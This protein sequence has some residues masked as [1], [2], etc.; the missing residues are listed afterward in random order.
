MIFLPGNEKIY[1]NNC[2]ERGDFLH[3]SAARVFFDMETAL[4]LGRLRKFHFYVKNP[5]SNILADSNKVKLQIWRPISLTNKPTLYLVWQIK[6]IMPA[7]NISRLFNVRSFITFNYLSF[8]NFQK[9]Y[10]EKIFEL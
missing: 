10:F 8:V 9:I 1:G 7:V 5:G 2:T 6:I 4:P 3:A